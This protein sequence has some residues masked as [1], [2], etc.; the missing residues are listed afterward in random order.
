MRFH[1][2][3]IALPLIASALALALSGCGKEQPR[4]N[5]TPPAALFQRPERP[6]MPPEA[7]SSEA[8][9]E[10]WREDQADWGKKLD[11]LFY[12]ACK[13]FEGA[14]MAVS[15]GAPPPETGGE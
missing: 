5:L 11:S 9:Y 8:A 10:K 14:G 13:W 2:S 1:T 4:P 3:R 7:V 12:G 15:C 6:V